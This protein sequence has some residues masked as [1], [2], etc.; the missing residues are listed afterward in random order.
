MVLNREDDQGGTC[1]ELATAA[2]LGAL[3]SPH[4]LMIVRLLAD[5]ELDVGELAASLGTSV[6]NTSHHLSRLRHA[7]LVISRRDG[8]RIPNQLSSH[9]VTALVRAACNVAHNQ[10]GHDRHDHG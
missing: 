2:L 9:E 1:D 5:R 7:G 4:R 10:Q 3:A 6:A 8:T